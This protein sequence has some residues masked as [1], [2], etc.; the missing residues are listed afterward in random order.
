MQLIISHM[1]RGEEM[2]IFVNVLT[3]IRLLAT[4]ILPV[5]WTFLSPITLI[6][7]V[8]LILLTDFFDGMLARKFHVQTLFGSI[9]DAVADKMFGII[10]LL[11]IARYQNLFYIPVVLEIVIALINVT[12]AFL[13][14]TT[15]SSFIGKSK[16]WLLGLA[17]ICGI[18]AIFETDI[19]NFVNINFISNALEVF[20]SNTEVFLLASVFLTAG[21][22]IM[23]TIDYSRNI[24]KELKQNPDKIEYN[25]KT[26]TSLKKALFD[27]E[28]YLK[29][30]NK[31]LSKHLLK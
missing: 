20:S 26:N 21:A 17:T 4:F 24:L 12:A 2:K 1:N 7:V 23:V 27:T 10:I 28:Y 22:E 19:I 8:A 18:V 6:V 30:K 31:S 5:L 11:I 29:N 25:F 16:M 14:A 13:G 3:I 15:K 9:A